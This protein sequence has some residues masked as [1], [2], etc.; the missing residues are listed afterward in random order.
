MKKERNQFHLVEVDDGADE[1]EDVSGRREDK[2]RDD[3]PQQDGR[4]PELLAAA[5]RSPVTMPAIT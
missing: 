4:R 5:A 2:V 3:E 1:E